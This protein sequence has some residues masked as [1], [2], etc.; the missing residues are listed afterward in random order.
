[1][2][3]SSERP[4][5]AIAGATGFVGTALRQALVSNY[6][7]IALTRS[8]V[9]AEENATS[10][11]RI[12]WRHCDLF[13]PYAVKRG[14][15]GADYAVY[16]VHSM[17]PSSRLTQAKVADLDLLMADNF[18]RAA[19]ADDLRQILYIGGLLPH[20][21]PDLPRYLRNRRD[22][23]QA[24]ASGTTPVT[25]LRAGL[26]VGAGGTWLKMILNLVRRLPV[27]VLPAWTEA[28]TQPIARGDVVRALT[29]CLGT[30]STYGETYDIGGPDRMTYRELLERTAQ[31]LGLTRHM[32]TVPIESHHLSKLWVRTFGG[33]PFAIVGPLVD[34]LRFQ[35]TV[36]ANPVQRWLQ[37]DAT[38]Y[39]TALRGAVDEQ[40]HPQPNPRAE[41]RSADDAVIRSNSVARSVQRLPLPPGYSAYDVANEYM[42]WLPSFGWPLLKCTVTDDRVARFQVRPFDL[43]LLELTFAEDR[44]PEGRQL[45][46]VTG[47]L[48]ADLS[49]EQGGRLEF[50][51]TLDNR[52]VIA[53]VHDFS[54]RLPWYVYNSTQALAHLLVMNGFGHHLRVVKR[55]MERQE[56]ASATSTSSQPALQ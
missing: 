14:L 2:A 15:E 41:L 9:R 38:P 24:L 54:P 39:E 5:V 50:R 23:E 48:L 19:E 49:G 44:S 40:G 27:M 45:F 53:A 1:M 28:E 18:A 17:H 56:A 33:V 7:V 37:A 16:L 36:H 42:E 51:C 46:Y 21:A 20:D 22:I 13:D 11:D 31:T 10:D 8:P 32:V 3:S 25:T 29:H 43:T 26:I 6:D 4:T 47:G 52:A 35:T 30:P 55:R 34:S 12:E